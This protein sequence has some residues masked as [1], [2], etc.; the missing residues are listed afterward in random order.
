MSCRQRDRDRELPLAQQLTGILELKRAGSQTGLVSVGLLTAGVEQVLV[1]DEAG[2]NWATDRR[3]GAV[4]SWIADEA[5]V[6][7]A[8]DR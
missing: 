3:P 1:T 4:I 8:P 6:S 5:G 2:V 7:W